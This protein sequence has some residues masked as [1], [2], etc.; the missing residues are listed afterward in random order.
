MKKATVTPGVIVERVGEE[1]MVVIPG[2]SDVVSLTGRPAEVLVDVQAGKDVDPTEPAL[3]T[4]SDLG[5]LIS[6]GMSRRGLITAGALGA[7]ASVVML[8][9]PAAAAASS[10][11]QTNTG[12]TGGGGGAGG[13]GTPVVGLHQVSGSNIEF[14]FPVSVST[15][16]NPLNVFVVTELGNATASHLGDNGEFAYWNVVN[17]AGDVQPTFS[18]TVDGNPVASNVGTFTPLPR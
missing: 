10:D 12:N 9:M 15:G 17:R 18:G 13:G 7:G 6:P 4:L 2:N 3:Q 14:R 16:S 11:P 8:S 5:I 1:L